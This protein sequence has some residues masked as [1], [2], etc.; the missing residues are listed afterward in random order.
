MALLM[1]DLSSEQHY[2]RL[3]KQFEGGTLSTFL[4]AYQRIGAEGKIATN[5]MLVRPIKIA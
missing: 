1:R 2:L 5:Q 4:P 3:Y